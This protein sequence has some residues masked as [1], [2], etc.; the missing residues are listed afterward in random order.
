MW[1]PLEVKGFAGA[2]APLNR[3]TSMSVSKA[4]VTRAMLSVGYRSQR[5]AIRTVGLWRARMLEAMVRGYVADDISTTEYFRGLESSEKGAVSF[6][7]AQAFTSLFAQLHM[8]LT[9]VV[10]VRGTRGFRCRPHTGGHSKKLGAETPSS[11]SRPDFIGFRFGEHHVFETK[12]R[13][14]KPTKAARKKA[15]GQASTIATI[16]GVPPISRVACHFA[17]RASDIAGVID[18]P[19]A[20]SEAEDLLVDDLNSAQAA[21][22]FFLESEVQSRLVPIDDQFVGVEIDDNLTYGIERK[23]L[24]LLGNVSEPRESRVSR[25]LSHLEERRQTY[26][27]R[28][29][30]VEAAGSDGTLVRDLRPPSAFPFRLGPDHS[31]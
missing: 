24:E 3:L 13:L 23:L 12:G 31:I 8:G 21:Y 28:R 22:A 6:L 9:F 7:L 10:H 5:A 15:L 26:L 18:D 20:S 27:S 16:N 30:G 4:D 14:R 19:E 11:G 2:L 17:F 29:E 1:C 25:I